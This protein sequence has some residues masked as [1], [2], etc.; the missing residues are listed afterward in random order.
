MTTGLEREEAAIEA[1]PEWRAAADSILGG[2]RHD[3][4]GRIG[5]VSGIAQLAQL[6][7]TLDAELCGTLAGEVAR[8]E[9]ISELIGL[10]AGEREPLEALVRASDLVRD[11]VD[12]VRRHRTLG[13][14]PIE[15]VYEDDGFVLVQRSRAVKAIVVLLAA[16][17]G[18][19]AARVRIARGDG[20]DF[21]QV[22]IAGA[23]GDAGVGRDARL[24][25]AMAAV[26]PSI[27]ALGGGVEWLD[28]G[29]GLRL[30]IDAG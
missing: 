20:N 23:G 24:E 30:P 26:R 17:A 25:Q 13:Q 8:L 29:I 9:R 18:S 22:A 19:G 21:V 27:T 3:L 5:V 11:A 7:G 1:T 10:V 4:N 12:L 15:V 2:I 16:V 28:T 6:D 14:V